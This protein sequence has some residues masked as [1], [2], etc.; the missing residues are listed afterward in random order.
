MYRLPVAAFARQIAPRRSRPRQPKHGIHKQAIVVAG[1]AL[2]P[3]L[4]VT[5]GS[6]RAH[7]ASVK[8]RLLK[9]TSVI[10]LESEISLLRHPL[11][12]DA[13]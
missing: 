13:A 4:P 8:V 10:D 1:P 5:S 12:E 2:S 9:I 7:C 3:F 6:E 11:N